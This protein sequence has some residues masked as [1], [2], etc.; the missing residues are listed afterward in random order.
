MGKELGKAGGGLGPSRRREG[1]KVGWECL[2]QA[3]LVSLG[4]SGPWVSPSSPHH[5]QSWGSSPWE[6]WADVWIGLREWWGSQS[7]V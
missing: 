7:A 4:R 6:A 3:H 2:R 5:T 1:G